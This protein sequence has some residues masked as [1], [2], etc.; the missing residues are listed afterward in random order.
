MLVDLGI[1]R[2]RNDKTYTIFTNEITSDFMNDPH[3]PRRMRPSEYV[4]ECWSR[5]ETFLNSLTPEEKKKMNSTNGKIF[6]I[7]IVTA[8]LRKKIGPFYYQANATL[9]PDVDYDI[10]T[11]DKKA[12]IPITISIKTSSRERYKQADLEAYAFS[13]VHRN[14]LNY[15]VLLNREDSNNVREKISKKETMGLQAVVLATDREFDDFANE[16][17]KRKLAWSIKI[18]LFHG[19]RMR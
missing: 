13:N 17:K 10:I 14:A 19:R 15:L 9:V 12:N 4:N 1:L 6:E 16:L 7:I 5:Y 8:L 11:Y 2:D 18:E 3:F